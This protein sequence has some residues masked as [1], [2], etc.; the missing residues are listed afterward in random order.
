MNTDND[1][2]F[3]RFV[4]FKVILL[5]NSWKVDNKIQKGVEL[6]KYFI[7]GE[8]LFKNCRILFCLSRSNDSTERV[9]STINNIW[10][11]KIVKVSLEA[12]IYTN[13]NYEMKWLEFYDF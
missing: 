11:N 10:N 7:E 3:V 8:F 12:C 1:E 6:F 9:F 5:E 4:V 13:C 2:L